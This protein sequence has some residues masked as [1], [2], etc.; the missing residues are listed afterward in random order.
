GRLG[1]QAAGFSA[2][3]RGVLVEPEAEERRARL[4]AAAG[5]QDRLEDAARTLEEAAQRVDVLSAAPLL[6]QLG[7]IYEDSL[8]QPAQAIDAFERALERD[9]ADEESLRALE[10]LY[11]NTGDSSKLAQN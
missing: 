2:I 4:L 3:E 7:S 5:A 10:R 1:D 11:V 9:E 6:R 8:R